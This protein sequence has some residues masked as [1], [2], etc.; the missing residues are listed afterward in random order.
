MLKTILFIFLL[1]FVGCNKTSI[2]ESDQSIVAFTSSCGGFLRTDAVVLQKSAL[3][4][5]S[6]APEYR[7]TTGEYIQ[8]EQIKWY[9]NKS[10]SILDIIHFRKVANCGAQL[11]PNCH[12]SGTTLYLEE[13]NNGNELDRCN[14]VFD[15]FCSIK[16]SAVV[17]VLMF[18]DNRW[19]INLNNDTGTIIVDTTI[20]STTGIV[21]P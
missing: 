4:S 21:I 17:N 18:A 19:T 12:V 8:V 5:D 3:G 9:Y 6:I 15:Q 1:F 20:L 13:S 10:D 11:M 14:C 2:N 7:I 16:I